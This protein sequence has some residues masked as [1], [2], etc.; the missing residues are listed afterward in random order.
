MRYG[1]GLVMII[2][3]AS[4]SP[5]V[6]GDR[7]VVPSE[8]SGV[9][10]WKTSDGPFEGALVDGGY[11]PVQVSLV[12]GKLLVDGQPF[13]SLPDSHARF[14][15]SVFRVANRKSFYSALSKTPG[16][17]ANEYYFYFEFETTAGK[18]QIPPDLLELNEEERIALRQYRSAVDKALNELDESLSSELAE[19]K[20]SRIAD[21]KE[22]AAARKS[23]EAIADNTKEAAELKKRLDTLEAAQNKGSK[24][25]DIVQF[26]VSVR[27][28]YNGSVVSGKRFKEVVS[29]RSDSTVKSDTIDKYRAMPNV[30]HVDVV[31]RRL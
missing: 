25:S 17:T 3:F 27:I 9:R 4:S 6:F 13:D 8:I 22:E 23:R 31:V 26:E 11:M 5:P 19:I 30:R 28:Y 1:L 29:G 16:R 15:M 10:Q 7:A 12:R 14:V 20:R 2:A 21:E 24:P 18:K